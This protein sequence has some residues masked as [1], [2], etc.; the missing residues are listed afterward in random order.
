MTGRP[1]GEADSRP[2]IVLGERQWILQDGPNVIGRSDLADI[3]IEARGV[4]RRHACITVSGGRATIEDLHSKNG[5]FLA[6]APVTTPLALTEG[7]VIGLGRQL[8]VVFRQSADEGTK[9]D[10]RSGAA[11]ERALFRR[12]G[13]LWTVVFDGETARLREVKGFTDLVRLLAAP[14]SDVHC[15]EL[16]DRAA[17]PAGHDAVLDDRARR[18]IGARAADLQRE[19]EDADAAHDLGR[20]ER[21]REELDRL[22]DVLTGAF[23]LRGRPRGLGSAVERARSTVTWRLRSAIKRIAAAH[24]PLGRHLENAVR[25]GY[26]CSYR[27]ERQV[28][29]TL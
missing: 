18:E 14:D 2:L 13:E 5:T 9:T 1:A 17:E 3:R 29:W 16:A 24:P 10:T 22:V 15:L 28:V 26:F 11:G 8:E 20:A 19:I 27:P 25:T 23:G 21:A 6:D 4:S 12:E 7:D